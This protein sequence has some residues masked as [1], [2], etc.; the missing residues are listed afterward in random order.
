M[1]RTLSRLALAAAF[2]F[3]VAVALRARR[4]V[5]VE[6]LEALG[7]VDLDDDVARHPATSWQKP[8]GVWPDHPTRPPVGTGWPD[9]ERPW[10]W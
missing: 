3:G 2:L 6:A 8:A 1:S 5:V 10:L 9:T 7:V 4:D